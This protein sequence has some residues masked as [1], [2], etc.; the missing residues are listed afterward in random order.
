M[1]VTDLMM[2]ISLHGEEDFVSDLALTLV[3]Y[4]HFVR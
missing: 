2:L 1:K 4:W 3:V